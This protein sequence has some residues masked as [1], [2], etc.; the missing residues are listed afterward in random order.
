M[1]TD[2]YAGL[3]D[4]A[5]VVAVADLQPDLARSR[6][7]ALGDAYRAEAARHRA[8][9][10]NARSPDDRDRELALAADDEAAAAVSIRL[11]GDHEALLADD[12]VEAIVVLTPPSVRGVPTVAGADAGKHV[13][14][15][16]PMARSVAEADEMVAAV[17][18]SGI[19]FHSQCGS[20][21]SRGMAHAQRAVASG[22]MGR[23]AFARVDLNLFRPAG[24]FRPGRWHGSWDGEGGTSVFHHGRYIIDPFLLVVGSP[25]V[26]VTA[27][28]GA[29]LRA[30]ETDDLSLALLK[31]ENGAL[32]MLQ[33]S[34][35]HHKNPHFPIYRVEVMGS[36][37]SLSLRQDYVHPDLDTVMLGSRQNAWETELAFGSQTL[38][39]AVNK[40]EALED[41]VAAAP[42]RATEEHQSRIWVNAILNGT[43]TPTPI[44]IPRAHV[45]LVRAV[46][47]SQEEHAPVSLPLEKD[48]PFYSF[49]G[50]LS[51][52]G[53]LLT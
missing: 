31:F 17:N 11:Y 5:Q 43:G 20:R 15:Q 41:E 4:V 50:R 18:A 6:A 44:E 23:M 25:V 51:A 1:Y 46:Y 21:Y 32:G 12:E 28:S 30:I 48:D 7:A 27:Y 36:D 33:S 35:L 47:K 2:I 8:L 40:L 10:H 42:P 38:P 34:L 3:A 53:P 26:E 9:G 37:A 24:Y 39:D 45:E 13:F 22:L 29:V 14:I 52:R 16:G 49:E 19:V